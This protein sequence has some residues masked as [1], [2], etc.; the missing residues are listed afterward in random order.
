MSL[1]ENDR[2]MVY[3][4]KAERLPTLAELSEYVSSTLTP[5]AATNVSV[6]A[7]DTNGV[8]AGTLQETISELA[9]RILFLE[10]T[11]PVVEG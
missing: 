10:N 2:V 7:D 8:Y 6:E 4:N 11:L 3:G 9:T 5:V 1:T